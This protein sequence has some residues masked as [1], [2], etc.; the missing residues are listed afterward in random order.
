M[1]AALA[2]A[3]DLFAD[4]LLVRTGRT[5]QPTAFA[6]TLEPEIR[7]IVSDIE[8]IVTSHET[9]E[10]E[11]AAN[12]F[13]V[14]ATDYASLMLIQ[15]L[16]AALAT[17]APNIRIQL[18]SRDIA[19]HSAR[20]QRSEIDLAIVPARFSATTSL[21]KEPL[22]TDRFVA[23]AWRENHEVSDPMTFDE[24]NRL[25]YLSYRLGPLELMLD[26]LLRELGHPRSADTLVE[27]FVVGALL[28]RGT[29]QVTFLQE[30]LARLLV[31][32]AELRLLTPPCQIPTLVET[33]TWHPRSNNDPAHAWLRAR[34]RAL[35]DDLET[36][37]VGGTPWPAQASAS[38]QGDGHHLAGATDTSPGPFCQ[39]EPH[40]TGKP[41]APATP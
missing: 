24:L 20:F 39:T 37:N 33:M 4:E 26:A 40:T 29:R 41:T 7:R 16:M 2:R 32:V 28:L 9:F 36:D 22:F 34:I 38:R 3:R 6:E 17:E 31:D 11:H 30:R 35:A 21:P 25:P 13:R 19:D 27:S 23:V 14:L 1:S 15:P 18:E 10:P 8:R 12:F 5:M